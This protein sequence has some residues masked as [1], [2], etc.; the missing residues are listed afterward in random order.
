VI[1]Q[2]KYKTTVHLTES[3]GRAALRRDLLVT[4]A[5]LACFGL[6]SVP[7]SFAVSPAPD[8]GYP[9][10]NTAEGSSALLNLT[11]GMSNTAAGFQALYRNTTG[12]YNT[13]NGADTMHGNRGAQNTGTGYSALM[14][15]ISGNYNTV[16]G[17]NALYGN[18]GSN[19]TAVGFGALYVPLGA[20]ENT[21]VGVSAL[22][23]N[24][25]GTQNTAVG[26]EAFAGHRGQQNDIALGHQ[27]GFVVG[28]LYNIEIGTGDDRDYGNTTRI[29]DVQTRTFIAGISGTA[30][31]GNPVVVNGN[32]RLGVATSS[33]RFKK[34]IKP[35]DKA[36]EAIVGLKPVSFQYKSDP[37]GTPRF[38]LIAEE[39][40]KV[41]PDLVA[42]DCKG[43]IYSVRY[44]AVNAILL[45]E[46]LEQHRRFLEEQRKVQ[47]Q[48]AA[49][50][51]L[52]STVAQQQKDFQTTIDQLTKRAHEQAYQIQKASAQVEA[53]MQMPQLISNS[54]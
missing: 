1:R 37:T 34:E 10:N 6:L 42:R 29:G 43:E 40:A 23:N 49:I 22:A 31:V 53:N 14:I 2:N 28:G 5:A 27:A 36:S 44:E 51:Q 30:V 48:Q 45:N 24:Y 16:N 50:T 7:K 13:A 33:A 19:N 15:N 21:A 9:G 20:S 8:G 11:S 32:G 46:F 47:E 41:N 39:V 18:G 35:I 38:G 3:I 26:F 4:L 54:Q 52:K 25:R 12:N 17:G